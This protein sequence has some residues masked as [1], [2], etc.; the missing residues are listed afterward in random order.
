M[1]FSEMTLAEIHVTRTVRVS[2]DFLQLVVTFGKLFVPCVDHVVSD[3]TSHTH[4]P[5]TGYCSCCCCLCF[6]WHLLRHYFISSFSL[7]FSVPHHY[8]MR[9]LKSSLIR[10]MAEKRPLSD[11]TNGGLDWEW[12]DPNDLS[13]VSNHTYGWR[14]K[15][16]SV[17]LVADYLQFNNCRER[18]LNCLSV[19][20][21]G[22]VDFK[23]FRELPPWEHRNNSTML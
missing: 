20:F 23:E 8:C 16:Q 18:C 12:V 19:H 1:G 5:W 11:S 21:L 6:R 4:T 22:F 2:S 14:F 15:N 10:I 17:C 7:V 13:L 9:A 3:Y